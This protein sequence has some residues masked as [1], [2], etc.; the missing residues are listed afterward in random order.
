MHCSHQSLYS[1]PSPPPPLPFHSTCCMSLRGT[2][3]F[4]L[5]GWLILHNTY[6]VRIRTHIH[7][8]AIRSLHP[9]VHTHTHAHTCTVPFLL[10]TYNHHGCVGVDRNATMA[11]GHPQHLYAPNYVQPS[12]ASTSG[13]QVSD[14][15]LALMGSS[16]YSWHLLAIPF[17]L[18]IIL[19]KKNAEPLCR[20]WN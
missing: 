9:P 6:S 8:H 16:F 14:Y 15:S 19:S 11:I 1:P 13:H 4:S 17:A 20:A 7:V 2:T 3:R 10:Y 5:V 12:H 18:T